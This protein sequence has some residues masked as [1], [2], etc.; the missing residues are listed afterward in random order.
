VNAHLLSLSNFRYKVEEGKEGRM[1]VMFEKSAAIPEAKQL[2]ALKV[3]NI[4]LLPECQQVIIGQHL[5]SLSRN[6]YAI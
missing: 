1:V 4:R 5:L 2:K 6:Y 3:V